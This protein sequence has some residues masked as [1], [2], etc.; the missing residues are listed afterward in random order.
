MPRPRAG[1]STVGIKG[2][3]VVSP[4]PSLRTGAASSEEDALA[5]AVEL[6]SCSFNT[7]VSPPT[8]P[9]GSVPRG[10]GLS[11]MGSPLAGGRVFMG[12]LNDVVE[13]KTEEDEEEDDDDVRMED[14]TTSGDRDD[15]ER[16]NT[17]GRSEEEDDG[18]F[19]RMEE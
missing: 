15:D 3:S 1:S 12:P 16:W 17:R 5:A 10:L 19:G 9:A 18:V 4:S 13:M 6:L 8:I 11:D 7:P 14:R 2:S